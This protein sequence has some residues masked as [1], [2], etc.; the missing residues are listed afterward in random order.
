MIRSFFSNESLCYSKIQNWRFL[1]F[2]RFFSSENIL[3]SHLLK[4]VF[5]F[6]FHNHNEKRILFY[7]RL[8]YRYTGNTQTIPTLT[9]GKKI[10][11]WNLT[12]G[13]SVMTKAQG[14]AL[15]CWNKK[16]ILSGSNGCRW[17]Y[18]IANTGAREIWKKRHPQATSTNCTYHKL[19]PLN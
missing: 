8:L 10:N 3:S 6:H 7:L 2:Y 5:I 11:K 1:K 17:D 19:F 9:L 15:N 4:L 13:E 16:R 14:C 12:I 18:S